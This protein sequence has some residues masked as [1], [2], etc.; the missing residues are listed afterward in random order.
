MISTCE[1]KKEGGC[2]QVPLVHRFESLG[3]GV[4]VRRRTLMDRVQLC[5][6]KGGSVGSACSSQVV[7]W[8][9]DCLWVPW[10]SDVSSG[11]HRVVRERS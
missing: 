11:Y 9:V 7:G 10:N 4:L 2:G 3:C 6:R 1:R 8:R 5:W